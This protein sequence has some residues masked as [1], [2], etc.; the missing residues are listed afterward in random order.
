MFDTI[1]TLPLSSE[2]FTQAIHPAEPL[3]A[4]GLSSGHVATLKLPPVP[5]EDSEDGDTSSVTGHGVID[6][7][8]RTRR[9]KGSC[10]CL[11]Y[12]LDGR[13]LISAGTDGIVKAADSET[14]RVVA[15]VALPLDP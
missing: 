11:G 7:A 3:L 15:K 1:C 10:R 4:V 13:T 14:G 8:W 9:H 2:L 6:A 12:S 5:N